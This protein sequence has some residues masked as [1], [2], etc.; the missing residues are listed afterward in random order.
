MAL[1][2][3]DSELSRDVFNMT[4]LSQNVE[5]FTHIASRFGQ[6]SLLKINFGFSGKVLGRQLKH[7]NDLGREVIVEIHIT[8]MFCVQHMRTLPL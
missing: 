8:L 7:H 2:I 3:F 4:H 5:W 6:K 1:K